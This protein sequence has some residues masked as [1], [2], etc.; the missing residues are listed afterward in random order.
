VAFSPTALLNLRP[1]QF[2]NGLGSVKFDY[3]FSNGN[4][5]VMSSSARKVH[6]ASD[7]SIENTNSNA[8]VCIDTKVALV[9][10]QHPAREL[11]RRFSSP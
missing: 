8:V 6:R 11:R 3:V 2:V 1:K 9:D 5:T 10:R 4:G 7:L